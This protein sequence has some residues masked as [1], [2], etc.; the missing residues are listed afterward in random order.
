MLHHRHANRHGCE[1]E[2]V[3]RSDLGPD[4]RYT[5]NKILLWMVVA[6]VLVTMIG[7]YMSHANRDKLNV[8][9]DARREIEKAKRK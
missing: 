2:A 3:Q 9:P 5:V 1:R 8:A 6:V 7:W 4:A